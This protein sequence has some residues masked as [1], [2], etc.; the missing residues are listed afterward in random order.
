[1]VTR[2]CPNQS[3]W[4]HRGDQWIAFWSRRLLTL[5]LLLGSWVPSGRAQT[6]GTFEWSLAASVSDGTG[7]SGHQM[8][9]DGIREEHVVVA[10]QFC[11]SQFLRDTMVGSVTPPLVPN[12]CCAGA[13][14]VFSGTIAFNSNGA[15]DD[16][17]NHPS[18]GGMIGKDI[19]YR[20]VA[21][22]DEYLHVSTCGS[23][24]DTMIAVY[25][26][27]SCP[28]GQ[29]QLIACADDTAGC[30]TSSE[31][32]VPVAFGRTYFIRVGGKNGAS[33]AGL[34]SID[35]SPLD[36][37]PPMG[38]PGDF[39]E[40]VYNL[41]GS[42]SGTGWSWRIVSAAFPEAVELSVPGV[43]G[44][45]F[46]VAKQFATSIND[47]AAAN[48]CAEEQLMAVAS[49]GVP[50]VLP[51]TLTIRVG[52]NTSFTLYV[53]PD[54]GPA[55]CMVDL[56]LPA[57]SFNPTIEYLPFA[58]VDCNR[59]GWSDLTDILTGRSRDTNA[60]GIPDECERTITPGG[61]GLGSG[62]KKAPNTIPPGSKK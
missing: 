58:Y 31:L 40:N 51:A 21:T 12:D 44:S 45:T 36:L 48:G 5:A 55:S 33:G 7:R 60:N 6:C 23:S 35:C 56:A 29:S 27:T 14:D 19:W 17:A 20:Y 15:T 39:K 49:A 28:F 47:Y 26:G 32:S 34:L 11:I 41:T 61:V 37:C 54:G 2:N 25:D 42:G 53:G 3:S 24:F 22:C 30:G 4:T 43:V 38:G 9:Y 50:P 13:I 62:N 8:V 10:G 52:G 18:C 46:D 57:C 16:G 59:N 1:M